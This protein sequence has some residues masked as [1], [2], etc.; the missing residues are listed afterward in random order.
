MTLAQQIAMW[1][2]RVRD[3]A[4]EGLHFAQDVYNRERYEALQD[5]AMEM[6]ARATDVPPEELEP[7]RSTLFS[8]FTPFV[9]G[10]GAVIDD[11]GRVL[12]IR[13][14]DNGRWALPG[15]ALAVGETPAEGVLREVLEETGI[16]CRAVA[17]L[18]IFDSRWFRLESSH[19]LYIVSF[20][21][22]PLDGAA[23]CPPSHANE[24]LDVRWFAEDALPTDMLA[25]TVT[26]LRNAYRIWREGGPAFFDEMETE[27]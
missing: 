13:R 24:I 17:L 22:Q 2:D 27:L 25:W 7:L 10:H 8:H 15:G 6:Y 19:H 1:A 21:C 3:I 26:E 9:G 4:A 16:P 5:L 20:L 23:A 11:G 18:G 12:L 14:A